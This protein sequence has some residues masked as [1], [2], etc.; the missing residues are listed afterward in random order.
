M[1][2]DYDLLGRIDT[3]ALYQ[4]FLERLNALL[5][6][7]AARGAQ[8]VATSGLR[9]YEQQNALYAQ[10][11]TAPGRKVTNARGGQSLHNFAVA[12]DFAPHVGGRYRGK[13]NPDY[14]EANY[15]IL[16]EEAAK[17]GLEWGGAWTSIKDTPHVQLPLKRYGVK[18]ADLD[19]EYRKGGYVAVF[20]YLD[21]FQW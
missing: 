10:G 7:C 6:A 11:R 9:T 2:E 3:A 1:A 18:L 13:L 4:P 19:R 20:A 8:Y 14:R 5:N 12:V 16:G 17:A 15:R 21:K